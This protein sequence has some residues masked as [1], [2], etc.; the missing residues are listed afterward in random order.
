MGSYGMDVD[1]A[2]LH[3]G[4]YAAPYDNQYQQDDDTPSP[5][6]ENHTPFVGYFSSHLL[7]TGFFLQCVSLVLMFVFYWAFGGTGIFIFDLYAGPE[8]VKVSSTFHLTISILMALYLLGTL[9]IAMFQVFVADNSKWCR[10]FRAGSKLL[11]AAVTLDL[12]SS[13]LRLVQ[14]LYA[15]FYMSMRWWARYQQTKSDWTLLHFGS[16]VH[17]FALF[18]YGAAFFYMEA[19]HDE[20][21]YEELA[22]SNLTLFKLAGLA[23]LIMVFSGFGAFFSILL[24]GAIVCATVWAFSFE[25]LLEKWSPELHSRDINADVLPEIKHEDEQCAYNE[26]NIY[27][28]YSVN[29]DNV[30]YGEEMVAKNMNEKYIDGNTYDSNIYSANN[31]IPTTYDYTQIEGQLKKNVEM[32]VTENNYIKTAQY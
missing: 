23:E 2:Y 5:R 27:E 10:G 30:E 21:T 16:I 19:Y 11:S 9:Y 20:G 14:Y 6:G 24:L 22:W 31:G 26:E 25:P 1:D 15:Y 28:P 8:C 29:P 12:L 17:S 13:I 4:Q 32:G 7:R 18:I 3:Q